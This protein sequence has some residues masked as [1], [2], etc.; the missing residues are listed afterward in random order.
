MNDAPH[1]V[2]IWCE[3]LYAPLAGAVLDLMGGSVRIAGVGGESSQAVDELARRYETQAT[4]DARRL[5]LDHDSG[6]V[7]LLTREPPVERELLMSVCEQS[8]VLALE[9]LAASVREASALGL[10]DHAAERKRIAAERVISIPQFT[11]SPG[12]LRTA[13]AAEALGQVRGVAVES[14]G[15]EGRGS[16]FARLYDAWVA[17]LSLVDTPLSIDASLA[18]TLDPRDDLRSLAGTLCAHARTAGGVTVGAIV[19]D[20]GGRE[21][22]RI[23]TLGDDRQLTVDDTAYELTAGDGQ[24]IDA[25]A[26]DAKHSTLADLIAAQWLRTL[27]RGQAGP[28][29]VPPPRRVASLA[30]C[31]ACL[32]SA[33]TGQAESPRR[34]LE[35]H[36]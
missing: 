17:V 7:L 21:G 36:R 1:R 11:E 22:R 34:V 24:T 16:L 13:D 18:G 20:R 6:S 32:L 9:P 31:E 23:Q 27:E 14:I 4:D 15:R 35:M 2:A 25:H 8:L 3:P 10:A 33:R 26:G 5:L 19:S 12:Y 28:A 30:C 29:P